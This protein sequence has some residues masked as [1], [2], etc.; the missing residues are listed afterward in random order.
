MAAT[1]AGTNR[2]AAGKVNDN[3]VCGSIVLA[4]LALPGL[5]PRSAV[6][7]NAPEHA[8]IEVKTEHYQDSQ[9]GF[10]RIKIDEPGIY[11]L[12]PIGQ[13]WSLSG[14]AV[15]D[16]VSGASP[17]YYTTKSGASSVHDKR[18][19]GDVEA[20]Y[21]AARS[22][23]GLSYA[24]SEENDY[25][26]NSVSA[27][28]IFSTPDNNTAFNV[29][30]SAGRDAIN[31]TNRI[32][33]NEHRTT[34][35]G[36]VGVTQALSAVDLVQFQVGYSTGHGYFSDAYKLFDNR[37]RR[38]NSETASLR[39][40]HHIA[41]FGATLRAN[42][43]F[44][45]DTYGINS[46]T[47]EVQWVQPV[48]QSWVLTP[49]LRYFTQN[50]AKFY[51]DPPPRAPFPNLPDGSTSSLDQRLSAFG[52][53]AVSQ[54]VEW[55]ITQHWSTD[56]KGEIYEQKSSYR[57]IGQGSPGLARFQYYQVQ[58]GLTYRY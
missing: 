2:T 1:D 48:G 52:A 49:G 36:I 5:L 31:P 20:T 19:S 57:F 40:N 13:H 55:H 6:A 25:D 51:V 42:Y 37:P 30:L 9:P 38:R 21:Y 27:D 10:Q 47:I 14:A 17:R 18:Y 11:A 34:Y 54:K 35:A 3:S 12:I 29:G 39:W 46:H 24:H 44:Y 8:L 16:A 53:Y 26:A 50:A 41:T 56:L 23:Y 43:R 58:F 45:Q 15:Y 28:A 4:A 22:S 7:D 33:V 32:V